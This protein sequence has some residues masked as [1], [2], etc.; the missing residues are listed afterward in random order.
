M[1][2][3]APKEAQRPGSEQSLTHLDMR[4]C[5]AG[6]AGNDEERPD[7]SDVPSRQQLSSFA[8]DRWEVRSCV[9]HHRY[10]PGLLQG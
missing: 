4:G 6:T 2:H 7:A 10:V 1:S 5:R 9:L 8:Q 3:E